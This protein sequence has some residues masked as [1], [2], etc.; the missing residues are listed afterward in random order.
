LGEEYKKL[1][2]KTKEFCDEESFSE[3]ETFIMSGDEL[4]DMKFNYYYEGMEAMLK[5]PDLS[6]FLADTIQYKKC[7]SRM[8]FM[9]EVE[10]ALETYLKQTR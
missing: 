9:R 7:T 1:A 8:G 5:D 6:E 10:L 4:N 3:E 2:Q